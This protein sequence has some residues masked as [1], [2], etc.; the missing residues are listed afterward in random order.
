PVGAGITAGSTEADGSSDGGA[1]ASPERG[2]VGPGVPRSGDSFADVSAGDGAEVASAIW[3]SGWRGA[4]MPTANATEARIRFRIPRAT[5]RRTRCADVT[6][7]S[8]LLP[9]GTDGDPR[10]PRTA[11]IVSPGP[12]RSCLVARATDAVKRGA[13]E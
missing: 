5:T 8:K 7:R 1:V 4:P 2:G 9:T 3:P 11:G 13:R 12:D 10:G 6:S